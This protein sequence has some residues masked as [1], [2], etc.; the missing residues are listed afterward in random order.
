[1]AKAT[2]IGRGGVPMSQ[3]LPLSGVRILDLSR[4]LAGPLSTMILGDLG[5]D[6]IKVEHPE[7]GDDTRD[8]GLEIAPRDTSY[9]YS[10]NRNKRS[11]ALDLTTPDGQQAL[12]ALADSADV[13]VE[14]FRVGGMERFGLGYE[15]LKARNP[16][17][18]YCAISGYDRRGPEAGRPGY[19]LVIQGESGVM[20]INGEEGR[21][22]LK[23]GI[24][25]VDM[26][27]GMYA[28][29]AI[30][31]AL[32]QAKSTGTGRR[33]DVALYDCGMMISSYYGLD[34]LLTDRDPPRY[35]NAH[36]SIVPY[37]VFD[38]ADG[39]LVIAV[40]NNAQFKAFC[41]EVLGRPEIAEEA[42]F[43]T[44]LKRSRNRQALLPLL[45]AEIGKHR[46]DELLERLA[47]AGIPSGQVL[48]LHAALTHERTTRAGLVA[49]FE[50][51]RAGAVPTMTTPWRFD[52][53]RL[54]VQRPPML[55]EHTAEILAEIAARK[56]TI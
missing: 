15:T 46:R 55:G 48:G 11:L 23:F 30:L 47:A 25:A 20:A 26:F 31:A 4:V 16:R 5:A 22:P 24:A 44:N 1:M 53:D 42:Q 51:P 10:F 32:Y 28:S 37:G 29:Q 41:G 3:G 33:I 54:P 34:A 12:L 21:P 19:D 38:A 56:E 17:L 9:Y 50:H 45:T 43:A 8:W 40:G 14:N 52:G 35:G 27:T 13:V 7:R 2:G 49:T 39:P 6:V 18:V 36:P